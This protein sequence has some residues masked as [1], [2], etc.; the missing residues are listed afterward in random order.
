MANVHI[1]NMD[2]VEGQNKFSV[3][4]AWGFDYDFGLTSVG[5]LGFTTTLFFSNT[6]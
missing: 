2:G 3:V 4:P 5:R 6:K 1:P